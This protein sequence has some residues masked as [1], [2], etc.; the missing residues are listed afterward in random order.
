MTCLMIQIFLD[1]ASSDLV[2]MELSEISGFAALE[3]GKL[4]GVH[5][6]RKEVPQLA[7]NDRMEGS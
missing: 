3:A 5:F 1:V 6:L 2:N 7:D 4:A